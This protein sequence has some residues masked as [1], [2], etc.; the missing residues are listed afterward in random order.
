M[1]DGRPHSCDAWLS[2]PS[3]RE[4]EDVIEDLQ[5]TSVPQPP[6]EPLHRFDEPST[7]GEVVAVARTYDDLVE[8]CRVRRKELQLAQITVDDIAGLQTGYT[9]KLECGDKRMGAMSLSCLLG[10]LGLE[11]V[12]VR[13]VPHHERQAARRAA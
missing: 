9:G 12:V 8:A 5:T 7:I 13:T 11:L 4:C 3:I 1:S 10:A 6:A 2:P